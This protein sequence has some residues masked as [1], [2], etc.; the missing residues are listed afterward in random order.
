VSELRLF[1]PSELATF[2]HGHEMKT[3]SPWRGWIGTACWLARATAKPDPCGNIPRSKWNRL[4]DAAEGRPWDLVRRKSGTAGL[5]KHGDSI[6][7][8]FE[9][10]ESLTWIDERFASMLAGLR[11]GRLNVEGVPKFPQ[12][13]RHWPIVGIDGTD[14]V[15]VLIMPFGD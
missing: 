9:T 8:G 11:P 10:S 3:G 6:Q 2:C 7:I 15:A 12:L 1:T 4:V 14:K 13:R 5:R